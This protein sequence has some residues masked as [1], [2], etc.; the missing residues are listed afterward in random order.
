MKR[1][2]RLT[3]SRHE[4]GEEVFTRLVRAVPG[5][6]SATFNARLRDNSPECMEVL[7]VLTEAGCVAHGKFE[8]SAPG[9]FSLWPNYENE[10]IDLDR[11]SFF[12]MIPHSNVMTRYGR[13]PE[14][15]LNLEHGGWER[16][17]PLL[18]TGVKARIVS[19]PLRSELEAED[20]VGMIFR[21]T[22]VVK[23]ELLAELQEVPWDKVG[24]EP[25]WELASSVVLPPLSPRCLLMNEKGDRVREESWSKRAYLM[26]DQFPAGEFH[27]RRVDLAGMPPF[28]VAQTREPLV[29]G[30]DQNLVLSRRVYDFIS[31]RRLKCMWLPVYVDD[32]GDHIEHAAIADPRVAP[33]STTLAGL[34]SGFL[35]SVDVKPASRVRME[36]ARDALMRHFRGDRDAFS[37]TEGDAE[38]WR[39]ALKAEG[40]APATISRTVLYARQCFRWGVKRGIVPTNPFADLKAGSQVNRERQVFIDRATIAKVIDAAPDAEWR[41]LIILSRFGGLRVPSEALA[42]KW[43]DVDWSNNRLTIPSPKT[44]HHEGRAERMIPLFPEIHD[45]LLALF[46]EAEER[47]TFI[48]T[49]YRD[50]ANLNPHFRRIIKRAGVA[51]WERAWHNLRASR[52]TELASSYPLHTVCAW[53]GNTKAIAAGHYLTVTD[54]DWMRAIARLGD[55]HRESGAESGAPEAQNASQ[56]TPAPNRKESKECPEVSVASGF[57]RDRA[58]PRDTLQSEPMGRAGL[59]PATP[60]FSVRCSTN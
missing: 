16:K 22:R 32:D 42:L 45:A 7:R 38:Q 51:P 15:L 60:A 59:E 14:G 8:P 35:A 52:Q 49:R 5:E 56:H 18:A 29:A 24:C 41:A 43:S 26:E 20:F 50:G 21:P 54:A 31:T 3:A 12:Q 23:G 40:Y 2:L 48:I 33:E 44:E 58:I 10:Q 37:I 55:A 57:A 39:A 25:Y 27:Y 28:D 17:G 13:G 53:I 6:Y 11:A 47:A 19:T 30:S 9:K 46:S 1:F 4:I 36:Q 34:L